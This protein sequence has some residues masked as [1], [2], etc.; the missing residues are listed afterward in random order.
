[1]ATVM[2][3][4][5][6]HLAISA[7]RT[8]TRSHVTKVLKMHKF[9]VIGMLG[10]FAILPLGD[11]AAIA[12]SS[13]KSNLSYY[14]TSKGNRLALEAAKA[15]AAKDCK[16]KVSTSARRPDKTGGMV[17]FLCVKDEWAVTIS[18]KRVPGAGLLPDKFNY[19]G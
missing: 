12:Q 16:G 14:T 13:K 10:A 6:V 5:G 3:E 19:A 18:F 4:T 17:T 9:T 11:G 1:M 8:L 15:M 7:R 2:F